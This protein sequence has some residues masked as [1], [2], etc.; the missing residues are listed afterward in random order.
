MVRVL[1]Y[2]LPECSVKATYIKRGNNLK[3]SSAPTPA[4]ESSCQHQ[5]LRKIF[6]EEVI[7]EHGTAQLKKTP[8]DAFYFE[9]TDPEHH[10]ALTLLT[11]SAFDAV[12]LLRPKPPVLTVKLK[13]SAKASVEPPKA[14]PV[15]A[16]PATAP[17]LPTAESS[18][19]AGPLPLTVAEK[20]EVTVLFP[21]RENMEFI[22]RRTSPV[23]KLYKILA[24]ELGICERSFKLLHEGSSVRSDDTPATLNWE[25][26]VDL[27]LYRMQSGGFADLS[28][29]P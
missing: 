4:L 18:S 12:V 28:L 21:D 5:E 22:L 9:Y 20:V 8:S 13:A 15:K 11:A 7:Q 17:I 23:E 29:L 6:C 1:L 26:Q 10:N 25:D 14:A 24:S 27:Y 16:A 2:S 3:V 19:D